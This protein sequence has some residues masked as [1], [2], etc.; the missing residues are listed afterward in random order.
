MPAGLVQ[1]LAHS[2]LCAAGCDFARLPL[3]GPGN[4]VRRHRTLG[5]GRGNLVIAI[6]DVKM[7][8]RDRGVG[9]NARLQR[10]A[11]LAKRAPDRERLTINAHWAHASS[12][13][14]LSALADTLV[15][16]FPHEPD[17]HLFTALGLMAAGRFLDARVPLERAIAIDAAAIDGSRSRCVACDALTTLISAYLRAD[18]LA[19]AERT[20]RAWVRLAPTSALA[21]QKL[22]EVLARQATPH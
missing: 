1:F 9:R 2:R 10:A 21:R 20:A 4:R 8:P 7:D 6:C 5:W 11:T 12:S 17:G 19:A 3:L 16:R 22:T 13:P 18:S 15:T 14:T